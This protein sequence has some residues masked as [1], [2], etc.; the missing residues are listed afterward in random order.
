MKAQASFET[1]K[2]TRI[3]SN[4]KISISNDGKTN[5]EESIKMSSKSIQTSKLVEK[6]IFEDKE[7]YYLWM[8]VEK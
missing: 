4:S 8:V 1:R 3:A 6:S 7:N 2:G 5:Y